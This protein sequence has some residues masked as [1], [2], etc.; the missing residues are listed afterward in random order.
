MTK[1]KFYILIFISIASCW[2]SLYAEHWD[3]VKFK[4]KGE[5]T[6][7]YYNSDNF[8]SDASGSLKGIEYDIFLA[9]KEYLVNRGID[10]EIKFKKADSFS[11]LYER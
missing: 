2:N 6:V 3:I 11:G 7:F 9:F 10:V 5:I 1:V 8:I 4:G